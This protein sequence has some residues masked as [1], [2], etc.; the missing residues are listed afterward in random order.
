ML[1]EVITVVSK[2]IKGGYEVNIGDSR[3]FCPFS[4][5]SS[6]RVENPEDF[7][8]KSKTFK[9]TEYQEDGR[10]IIISSRIIE[11][12]IKQEKIETLKGDLK[13]NQ[14]IKGQVISFEK[15]GAFVD[16]KGI[17]ALLPISEISRSRVDDIGNFLKIGQDIDAKRNNF[18]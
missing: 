3:A 15:F 2:V 12:E 11:D 7:V 4:Q 16:V 6:Q 14:I 17:R 5:I 18:V 13:E 1:Y 9:I 10:N 8:G